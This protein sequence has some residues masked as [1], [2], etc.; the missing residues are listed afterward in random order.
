MTPMQLYAI[1]TGQSIA[2]GGSRGGR[3][4]NRQGQQGGG[5]GMGQLTLRQYC[6]QQD[7]DLAKTVQT[8]REKGFH[9]QAD[10]TIREIAATGGVHPSAMRDILA[11]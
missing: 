11:Q 7:L 2:L 8:L 3:G 5:Y 4:A 6:D 10:M 9:A 1:A